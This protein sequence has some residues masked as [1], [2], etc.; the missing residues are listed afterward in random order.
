[1]SDAKPRIAIIGAGPTGLEAAL[2]AIEGGFPFTLY[3]ASPAVAGN[4]RAWGHV[5]LFTPWEMNVSPRMRRHLGA[6]G[7][8]VPAGPECPT[9]H[10]LAARLFEPLAFLPEIAPHLR[11]GTRVLSIGRQ[12]LLK[13]EEIATA[14]RGR[15]P[16]RLL[17]ADGAGREWTETA[18]AVI[19]ATGTWENPNTL[20][21]GGIPAPGEN[22][23]AREIRRDIPDFSS[24]AASW[25]GKKILLAG[26]GH[27]AQTAARELARLAE[28][29]PG[30]EVI[31]VLRN[32]EPGWGTREGDPL[33]ERAGLAAEAEALAQGSSPAVKARRGAVVEHIA[34]TNG[35]FEVVLRNGSGP[36]TI[37]VD[38]VLSLTG[39]VGDH[40]L[41]RQLQVHECYA[42]CGPIKLS[43]A[44]LGAG[45]SDCLGQT[46]HG[47]DTLTN[48]EPNFF[49]LGAKSYGR[50]NTFLM[51]IGWEQVGEV[52]GMLG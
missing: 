14:E 45:S 5:R 32:P 42:T 46:T 52:F 18:D 30:T 20:G 26:A 49:I 15:R 24:E 27:S 3:E 9:G 8:E 41:Y 23:L 28:E 29:A 7:R 31:W 44:I 36:E 19:D 37:A 51:R 38:R 21:D 43:A 35:R 25:A 17:L 10:D 4:V 50:N 16:F 39:S 22:G 48:P 2:A 6:A 40:G 34:K 12:G 13:H 47:A 11:L 1:M 33:P